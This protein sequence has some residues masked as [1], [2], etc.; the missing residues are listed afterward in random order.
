ML[1]ARETTVNTPRNMHDT[2]VEPID[3]ERERER[4]KDRA[5]KGKG[6]K[7]GERK[8]ERERERASCAIFRTELSPCTDC[9][10]PLAR[11]RQ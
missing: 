4:E 3:R 7:G 6:E 1:L 11:Y 2:L 9:S 5:I 8:R 10:A